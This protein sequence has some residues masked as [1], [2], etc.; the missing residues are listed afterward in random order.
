MLLSEVRV[1][2]TDAE[3]GEACSRAT[4]EQAFPTRADILGSSTRH[5]IM[6]QRSYRARKFLFP[7]RSAAISGI[8]LLPSRPLTCSHLGLGELN[9]SKSGRLAVGVARFCDLGQCHLQSYRRAEGLS[10]AGP[11]EGLHSRGYQCD[12]HGR[13]YLAALVGVW[14][15]VGAQDRYCHNGCR[16]PPTPSITLHA[17]SRMG[18]VRRSTNTLSPGPY[19]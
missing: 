6:H 12:H 13:A 15:P 19:R 14:D 16:V 1:H 17:E 7:E 11:V 5:T 10:T 18:E 2:C 4:A 9:P 3:D 8:S